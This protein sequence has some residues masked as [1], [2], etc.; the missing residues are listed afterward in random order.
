MSSMGI[1]LSCATYVAPST[2]YRAKLHLVCGKRSRA[3]R[4]YNLW[5]IQSCSAEAIQDTSFSVHELR[6]RQKLWELPIRRIPLITC[7]T[8][9]P[10]LLTNAETWTWTS[11]Q[12]VNGVME[13]Q[14]SMCRA[15]IIMSAQHH[16]VLSIWVRDMVHARAIYVCLYGGQRVQVIAISHRSA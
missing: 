4:L 11:N 14:V 3:T 9:H 15:V 2:S 6:A 1:W 16:V 7:T 5:A 13:V 8:C 10:N 12:Q